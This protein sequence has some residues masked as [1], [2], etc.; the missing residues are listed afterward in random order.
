MTD[1]TTDPDKMAGD[2]LPAPAGAETWQLV[3]LQHDRA[4]FAQGVAAER[5]RATIER[6][7]V[8]LSH[9]RTLSELSAILHSALPRMS[10]SSNII[11]EARSLAEEA[12]SRRKSADHLRAHRDGLIR[13]LNEVRAQLGADMAEDTIEAARRAVRDGVSSCARVIAQVRE[14]LHLDAHVDVVAAARGVLV[15]RNWCKADAERMTS[16]R[17]ELLKTADSYKTE[18]DQA[19][20]SLDQM[21]HARDAALAQRDTERTTASAAEAARVRTIDLVNFVSRFIRLTP[22]APITLVGDMLRARTDHQAE[23]LAREWERAHV[24]AT[25]PDPVLTAAKSAPVVP[26][27]DAERAMVSDARHDLILQAWDRLYGARCLRSYLANGAAMDDPRM[28]LVERMVIAASST[29][30]GLIDSAPTGAMA[31][32]VRGRLINALATGPGRWRRETDTGWTPKGTAALAELHEAARAFFGDAYIN[33][34]A[35]FDLA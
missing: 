34:L 1:K 19:R 28:V 8:R 12:V 16:L 30:L 35:A 32:P 11:E 25:A 22:A 5:A 14:A 3:L 2:A 17:D 33:A 7:D 26:F 6:G 4:L 29:L 10:W 9:E 24:P 13:D 21:R 18:R 20:A 15:E 23:R 27:S 31:D